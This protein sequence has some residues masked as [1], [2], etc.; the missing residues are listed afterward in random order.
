MAC[1]C[2][3]PRV[4]IPS[5]E[6]GG[7]SPPPGWCHTDHYAGAAPDRPPA[8]AAGRAH[9]GRTT[10]WIGRSA[11]RGRRQ[12]RA[13]QAARSQVGDALVIVVIIGRSAVPSRGRGP[14]QAA[15]GALRPLGQ[16]CVCCAHSGVGGSL[17]A[18]AINSVAV[19]WRLT[20]VLIACR[21]GPRDVDAQRPSRRARTTRATWWRCSACWPA[22]CPQRSCTTPRGW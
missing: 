20:L 1:T 3:R 14:G 8:R 7:T 18:I 10:P 15:A 17:S 16:E 12:A 13:R 21:A 4:A 22:R 2:G 19:M 11:R 5:R 9:G 6:G